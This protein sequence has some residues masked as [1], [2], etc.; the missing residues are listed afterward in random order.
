MC[1]SAVDIH[2]ASISAKHLLAACL[3]HI[4]LTSG[5][6]A[7]RC[8]GLRVAVDMALMEGRLPKMIAENKASAM[9]GGS[10]HGL[11]LLQSGR[12]VAFGD[13]EVNK[14]RLVLF[15]RQWRRLR[16]AANQGCSSLW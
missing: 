15:G 11:V 5:G 14:V 7:L 16:W 13:S 6:C 4:W 1:T 2:D 9:A 10:V 8:V 3:R 12:V